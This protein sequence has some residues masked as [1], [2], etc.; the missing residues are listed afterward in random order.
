MKI[1][2]KGKKG[3]EQEISGTKK[4]HV[5]ILGADDNP[6][7]LQDANIPPKAT[8]AQVKTQLGLPLEYVLR[9]QATGEVLNNGDDIFDKIEDGDKLLLNPKTKVGQSHLSSFFRR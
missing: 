2:L 3:K 9:R 7:N 6:K 1:G 4:C 8:G 5:V